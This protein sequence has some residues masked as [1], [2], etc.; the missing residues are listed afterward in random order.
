LPG[1]FQLEAAIQSV[2]ARRAITGATDWE[3]VVQLYLGLMQVAPSIGAAVAHAATLAEAYGVRSGIDA[4]NGI[5]EE[6]VREYQP[7]WAARAELL[8]RSGSPE[9][10]DARDRALGLTTDPAVRRFLLRVG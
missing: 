5:P 6:L 8:R 4:L 7:Y 10:G 2:H 9:A 1:R 3:T